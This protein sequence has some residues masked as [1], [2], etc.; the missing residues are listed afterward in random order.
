MPMASPLKNCDTSPGK[1]TRLPLS[2]KDCAALHRLGAQQ[3]LALAL[4]ERLGLACRPDRQDEANLVDEIGNV[5]DHVQD[6]LCTWHVD[7][8]AEDVSERVD[9][10]A[11]GHNQ[12]HGL[13]VG[14]HG[15][16]AVADS[17]TSLTSEDLV[18]DESPPS[19]ANDEAN[20]GR[21]DTGLTSVTKCKHDNGAD[22]E[23]PEHSCADRLAG[24][25]QDEVELNHQQRASDSP[26]DVTVHNWRLVDLDPVL[27][28]VH[29]VDTSN[30]GDQ[31]THVHR[32]L[33][34]VLHCC[35]LSEQ[36]DCAS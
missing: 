14:G 15:W 29:V 30:Q 11:N 35:S 28:H 32:G 24:S 2:R 3:L 19:H 9:G 21:Q 5:V 6:T 31:T 25:L 4:S 33:P 26:I 20:Q 10:P 12:A 23:P 17:A 13:E 22:Q 34:V 36:E 16:G 27:T 7:E 1:H 8:S 18:E